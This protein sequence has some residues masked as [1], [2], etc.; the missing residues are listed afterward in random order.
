MEPKTENPKPEPKAPEGEPAETKPAASTAVTGASLVDDDKD[1]FPKSEGAPAGDTPAPNADG[2]PAAQ[3]LAEKRNWNYGGGRPKGS[4]DKKPRGRP[5]R[6][7]WGDEPMRPKPGEKAPDANAKI[8]PEEKPKP[9]IDYHKLAAFCVD[10]VTGAAQQF[11]GPIW[12]PMP[13]PGMDIPGERDMMVGHLAAYLEV[14]DIKDIPP[15]WLLAITVTMYAAPR[16]AVTVQMYMKRRNETRVVV[17]HQPAKQEVKKET[18]RPQPEPVTPQA[19]GRKGAGP[20]R[21]FGPVEES[22]GGTD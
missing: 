1:T 10:T 11:G 22:G 2:S 3:P 12:K 6:A 8:D 5:E 18:E 13:S 9:T 4:K 17:A 21:D 14:N 20:V 7:D 16:I 15:G 19:A